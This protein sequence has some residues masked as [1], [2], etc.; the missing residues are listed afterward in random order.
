MD[1]A[2]LRRAKELTKAIGVLK[3]DRHCLE[4]GRFDCLINGRAQ[5]F[6][7]PTQVE[8]FRLSLL[9]QVNREITKL[10][11]EFQRL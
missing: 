11:N 3:N 6:S 5:K 4:A 8:A 2:G 10:E 7:W 9:R 1:A